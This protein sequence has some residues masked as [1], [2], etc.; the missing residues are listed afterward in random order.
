MAVSRPKRT[1][2]LA[3]NRNGSTPS[4]PIRRSPACIASFT[5]TVLETNNEVQKL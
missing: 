3:A 5:D 2:T 1:N 4:Q